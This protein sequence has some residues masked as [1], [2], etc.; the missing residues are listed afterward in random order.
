MGGGGRG[1]H[2]QNPWWRHRRAQMEQWQWSLGSVGDRILRAVVGT[3]E[4]LGKRIWPL[5][6]GLRAI[7]EVTVANSWDTVSGIVGG[8]LALVRHIFTLNSKRRP[9]WVG[10]TNAPGPITLHPCL[11]GFSDSDGETGFDSSQVSP[12]PGWP[13]SDRLSIFPSDTRSLPAP[14]NGPGSRYEGQE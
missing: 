14:Q 8:M 3:E 13:C 2:V 4:D 1:Q 9:W 11:S 7:W 10:G 6:G 5:S 12:V